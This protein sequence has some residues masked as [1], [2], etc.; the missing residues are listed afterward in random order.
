VEGSLSR[1]NWKVVWSLSSIALETKKEISSSASS[2]SLNVVV[3]F[4]WL[5]G[6][7][8]V[9]MTFAGTGPTPKEIGVGD[10][11]HLIVVI[12]TTKEQT[13]SRFG[14]ENFEGMWNELVVTPFPVGP[15]KEFPHRQNKKTR[16]HPHKVKKN[17]PIKQETGVVYSG[18]GGGPF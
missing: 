15:R 5:V 9:T 16:P 11:G 3:G 2:P 8:R 10:F 12:T 6:G 14:S 1:I 4:V 17:A 18:L 13:N 7:S